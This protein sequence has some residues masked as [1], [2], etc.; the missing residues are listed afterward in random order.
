MSGDE[1]TNLNNSTIESQPNTSETPRTP[2]AATVHLSVLPEETLR[3]LAPK[4]GGR[5][6]D[7]TL[8]GGGHTALLLEATEPD[9]RVLGIDA[10]ETALRRVRSR[11]AE[12]VADGRL[13]TR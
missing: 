13:L 12:A 11:L 5:Y 10:D 4:P 8:G 7:G 3:G 9:G 1:A 2:P 6:I